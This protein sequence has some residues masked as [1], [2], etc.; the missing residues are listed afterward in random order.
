MGKDQCEMQLEAGL[1]EIV[2][3]RSCFP[4]KKSG[5]EGIFRFTKRTPGCCF[6]LF[7]WTPLC[8]ESDSLRKSNWAISVFSYVS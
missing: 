7:L 2:M 3:D 4:V 1:G 5:L 6:P 8:A